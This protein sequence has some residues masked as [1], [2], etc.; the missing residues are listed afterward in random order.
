MRPLFPLALGMVLGFASAATAQTDETGPEAA[1]Q[2]APETPAAA[3]EADEDLPDPSS[4]SPEERKK[5]ADRFFERAQK[6]LDAEEWEQACNNFRVSMRYDTSVSTLANIARCEE[7]DGRL[8]EAWAASNRARF[9]NRNT[10][11]EARRNALNDYLTKAIAK[12][13]AQLPSVRIVVPNSPAG[14]QIK[15]DGA[16]MPASGAGEPFPVNPGKHEITVSAPGYRTETREIDVEAGGR[17]ELVISLEA[18]EDPVEPTPAPTSV[19]V[20]PPPVVAPDQPVE[21]AGMP[22]WVW[23]VGVIGLAALGGAIGLGVD[24]ATARGDLGDGCIEAADGVLECPDDQFD[25]NQIDALQ[26]RTNL[27]LG[28]GIGLGVLAS[29]A[30]TAAIVGIAT[31]GAPQEGATTSWSLELDVGPA[32]GTGGV[33]WRF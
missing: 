4:L 13:E 8:Y 28:L 10:P 9:L 30:I 31:G 17:A 7:H 27:G 23:P 6:Q 2:P 1:P 22:V 16:V 26:R 20:A 21:E 32:G 33:R 3:G 25:Q 18:G 19:P 15:S 5:V 24:S 11:D 14:L 29:G 12:L